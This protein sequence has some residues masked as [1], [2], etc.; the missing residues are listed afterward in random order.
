MPIL[1]VHTVILTFGKMR[2]SLSPLTGQQYILLKNPDQYLEEE[3]EESIDKEKALRHDSIYNIEN[4]AIEIGVSGVYLYLLQYFDTHRCSSPTSSFNALGI[5]LLKQSLLRG[6]GT[7][8]PLPL[9]KRLHI[10]LNI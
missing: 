6:C 1:T 10:W 5:N 3:E 7:S 8:L 4:T 9:Q 2:L